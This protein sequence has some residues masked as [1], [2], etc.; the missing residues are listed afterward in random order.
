MPQYD[1]YALSRFQDA[2]DFLSTGE[3]TFI[4]SEGSLPP[5]QVLLQKSHGHV[6][7]AST[8]PLAP[9]PYQGSPI[10]EEIRHAEGQQLRPGPVK[11]LADFIQSYVAERLDLLLPRKR[12]DLTQH[13]A[14]IVAAAVQCHMFRLPKSEAKYFLDLINAGSRTD[15]D[16]GGIQVEERVRLIEALE[17]IVRRRRK[18]GADGNFPMVDGMLEYRID[19][20]ALAD[21]EIARSIAHIMIG[22]TETVPKIVAHGLWELSRNRRQLDEVRADIATNVPVAFKE[23]VRYCGP[24]QWFLRT[25]HKPIAIGGQPMNVG[26]RVLYVVPSAARDERE[27][28]DDAEEF[29]WNREIKRWVNF[30]WGARFCIGYHLA[31]LEGK[32]LVEQFLRRVSDFSVIEDEVRRPPSSFQWGFTEVPVK[33]T[34]R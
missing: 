21:V 23:M 20:R 19:G 1:T 8:D 4:A 17:P 10:H 24:A 15:T 28:G 18:E 33:V 3:N 22:G 25:V 31:L 6:Q 13:Y 34:S 30:G 2:Y 16:G 11:G 32:I 26:Q 12:F 14:G 9:L 27:Y 7:L 5:R 29:R